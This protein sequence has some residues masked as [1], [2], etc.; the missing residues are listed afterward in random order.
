M[1]SSAPSGKE[2]GT[3]WFHGPGGP[4][5]RAEDNTIPCK[6][7]SLNQLGLNLVAFGFVSRKAGRP[8]KRI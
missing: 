8:E 6:A 2:F 4:P 5:S 3:S 1:V 7:F